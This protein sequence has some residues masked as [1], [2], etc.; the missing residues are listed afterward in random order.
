MKFLAT[1]LLVVASTASARIFE[2][3]EQEAIQEVAA[4]QQF[5]IQKAA[6]NPVKD[7][8]I[9][10]LDKKAELEPLMEKF[11]LA[12]PQAS[13]KHKFR[14]AAYGIAVSGVTEPQIQDFASNGCGNVVMGVMENAKAH[15]VQNG[16]VE[17]GLDRIDDR[18]GMD[19]DYAPTAN[20][21][22]VDIYVI[23]VSVVDV[24]H[25][26]S[27]NI[28]LFFGII[29]NVISSH[30]FQIQNTTV[31]TILTTTD[32]S[33]NNTRRIHGTHQ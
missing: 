11:Q 19:G 18:D 25:G 23:D 26:K 28:C 27:T 1:L 32:G 7:E 13:I 3:K 2:Q 30:H 22:G 9:L 29:L 20:G 12:F 31:T 15:M 5:S 24:A 21:D 14:L 6:K 4:K 8:Y 16:N 33:S 10:T 17:W